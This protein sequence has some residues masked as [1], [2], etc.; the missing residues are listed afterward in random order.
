M[1][2][3]STLREM[4]RRKNITQSELGAALGGVSQTYLS[5]IEVNAKEPS[6][7][8]L[9]KICAFYGV[10]VAVVIWQST[11]DKDISKKKLKAWKLIKPNVD[12]LLKSFFV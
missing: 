6:P 10:P 7:E 12:E 5:Q 4:R 3:G 11:G 1:D 2:I 9:R 8:M